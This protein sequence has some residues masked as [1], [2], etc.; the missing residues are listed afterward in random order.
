MMPIPASII[1]LDSYQPAADIVIPFFQLMFFPWSFPHR[2]GGNLK[3]LRLHYSQIHSWHYPIELVRLQQ[4]WFIS[5]TISQCFWFTHSSLF[6][7]SMETG[8]DFFNLFFFCLWVS[9]ASLALLSFALALLV[10]E[11]E[12]KTTPA[13][14]SVVTLFVLIKIA[15][16]VTLVSQFRFIHFK[17]FV[18]CCFQCIRSKWTL[19]YP[20]IPRRSNYRLF[21]PSEFWNTIDYNESL[22]F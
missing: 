18:F 21:D 13:A 5:R 7:F 6:K 15:L 4:S 19:Q 8:A 14:S 11:T 10:Q 20:A 1:I 9:I 17:P 16:L 3:I 12:Y 2:F 22:C